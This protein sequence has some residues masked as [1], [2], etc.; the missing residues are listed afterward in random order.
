MFRRQ[1]A[2]LGLD[3]EVGRRRRRQQPGSSHA[4]EAHGQTERGV[5]PALLADVHLPESGRSW[6]S[7][8][9][10]YG[11]PS[12]PMEQ[13]SARPPSAAL[14]RRHLDTGRSDFHHGKVRF[15]GAATGA[16]P[17]FWN[18]FPSRTGS[19]ASV[20]VARAF[21]VDVAAK[22]TLPFAHSVC[23]WVVQLSQSDDA[24]AVF[25]RSNRFSGQSW[26]SGRW[27]SCSDA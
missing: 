17:C 6:R 14:R 22:K 4:A 10:P 21:V 7:A 27:S 18:V 2:Q 11:P 9:P 23:H 20:G 1:P 16:I 5:D 24:G 12:V 15:G 25:R 13:R 8:R 19:H 26:P 3:H